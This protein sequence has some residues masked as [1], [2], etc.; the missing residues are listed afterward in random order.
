MGSV[1]WKL[2]STVERSGAFKSN[3]AG[4]QE[5]LVVRAPQVNSLEPTEPIHINRDWEE[6]VKY[7][8]LISGKVF[9]LGGRV[10]IA[11]KFTPLQK[12]QLHRIR[13]FITET[14]T[15]H[16]RNKRYSRVDK[17]REVLV[18]EKR[19]NVPLSP[20][21]DRGEVRF[22]EGGEISREQ[23]AKAR[24]QAKA[25]RER[26]A[27]FT[28]TVPEPLPEAIDS[29]MGDI[30]LGLDHMVGQTEIEMDVPLPTCEQMRNDRTKILHPDSSFKCIDVTH[31][32]KVS[33]HVRHYFYCFLTL[34]SLSCD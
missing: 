16:C 27:K 5:V 28:G 19:A 29:L 33:R 10:P 14:V 1:R 24:A 2:E 7:E 34:L 15:Y 21:F 31:W 11:F 8:I 32:V 25:W 30:D 23:R 22:P 3:L 17:E 13:V 9:P 26:I 20:D 12:I 18:L 6:Q 4:T